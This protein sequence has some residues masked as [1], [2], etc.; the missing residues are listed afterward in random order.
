MDYIVVSNNF[1][2]VILIGLKT[3]QNDGDNIPSKYEYDVK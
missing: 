1:K 3:L 2:L